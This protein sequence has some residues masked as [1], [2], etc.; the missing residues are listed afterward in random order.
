MLQEHNG[1]LNFTTDMWTMLNHRAYV[2]VTI[3]FKKDGV[4]IC[5]IL[6]VVEVAMSHSSINIAAAFAQILEEFSVSDKVSFLS[7]N[8]RKAM[9]LWFLA[10]VHN[11][12]CMVF[13]PHCHAHHQEH[14]SSI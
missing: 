5:I 1:A 9:Y 12:P 6:N 2:V 3:H 10:S 4:P 8:T 7:K 13:Q 14:D 11:Q